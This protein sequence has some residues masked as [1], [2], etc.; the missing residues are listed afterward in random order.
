MLAVAGS[1]VKA[2]G[3]GGKAL[4][5]VGRERGDVDEDDGEEDGGDGEDGGD[6]TDKNKVKLKVK[7]SNIRHVFRVFDVDRAGLS[8]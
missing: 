4:P 7:D 5:A 3:E 2:M 1:D 8:S 6:V